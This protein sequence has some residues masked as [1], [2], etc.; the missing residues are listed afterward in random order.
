MDYTNKPVE[1]M[2]P[3]ETNYRRLASLYG[4]VQRRRLGSLTRSTTKREHKPLSEDLRAEYKEAVAQIEQ[5]SFRRALAENAAGSYWQLVEDH[6]NGSRYRR[7]LGDEYI[8]EAHLLHVP[9]KYTN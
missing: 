5:L 7:A 9:S 6:P 1:N 3:D 8:I 4:T 2:H